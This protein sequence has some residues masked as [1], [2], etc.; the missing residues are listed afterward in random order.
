VP[1]AIELVEKIKISSAAWMWGYL[2]EEMR[3]SSNTCMSLM[4]SFDIEA[5]AL[6]SHSVYNV[7]GRSVAAEFMDEDGWLKDG[8][9]EFGITDQG[10]TRAEDA[11]VDLKGAR[12]E[13][14]ET[15]HVRDDISHVDRDARSRATNHVEGATVG[16]STQQSMGPAEMARNHKERALEN[17]T[18]VRENAELKAKQDAERESMEKMRAEMQRM[19]EAMA[20]GPGEGAA[21]QTQPTTPDGGT[22]NSCKTSEAAGEGTA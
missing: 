13:L 11:N 5:A 10:M 4:E 15:L 22:T 16:N 14:E 20:R 18:L 9:E 8:E 3:F 19:R 7:N 12:E 1:A 17:A 21:Y 2:N 6:A